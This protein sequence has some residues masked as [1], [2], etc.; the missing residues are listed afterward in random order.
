MDDNKVWVTAG[1]G[2]VHPFH[3]TVAAAGGGRQLRLT[4]TDRVQVDRRHTDVI[5]AL[6]D[7]D[8]VLADAPTPV[9]AKG[10]ELAKPADAPAPAV[11]TPSKQ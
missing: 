7:G 8:L 4:D 10:A 3:P 6:S 2:R 5:R 9:V 11:T 1:K